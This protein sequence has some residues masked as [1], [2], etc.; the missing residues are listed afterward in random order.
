MHATAH[1]HIDSADLFSAARSGGQVP[2]SFYDWKVARDK[3]LNDLETQA[4]L[5]DYMSTTARKGLAKFYAL[6]LIL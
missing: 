3:L 2:K 5:L 1:G 4:A 6:V